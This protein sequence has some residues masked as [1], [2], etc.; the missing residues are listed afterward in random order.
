[1]IE[2]DAGQRGSSPRGFGSDLLLFENPFG[3]LAKGV[4]RG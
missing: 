3:H 4:I 1:V 2:Y